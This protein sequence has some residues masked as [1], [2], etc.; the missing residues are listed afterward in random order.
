[1]YSLAIFVSVTLFYLF[2]RLYQE[3]QKLEIFDP[4]LTLRRLSF[5][6]FEGNWQTILLFTIVFIIGLKTHLNIALLIP[7][8]LLFSALFLKNSHAKIAAGALLFASI[9]IL[10]SAYLGHGPISSGYFSQSLTPNWSYVAKLFE[11]YKSTAITLI[12][13]LLP[14]PLFRYLPLTIKF[15]YI[16]F[17]T[18]FAFFFFAVNGVQFHDPRYFIFLFPL[19]NIGVIFGI[20]VLSLAFLSRTKRDFISP[21]VFLI[22]V[23]FVFYLQI[24]NACVENKLFTCPI[25]DKNKVFNLDRWNYRYDE[26]YE[27]TKSQITPNTVVASRTLHNYYSDKYQI[28]HEQQCKLLTNF[29]K[30]DECTWGKIQNK[31]V[32]L[33]VYPDLVYTANERSGHDDLYNFLYAS[34]YRLPLYESPDSRIFIYQIKNQSEL[35]Y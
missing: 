15:S 12:F 11:Y 6:F 26:G 4:K 25:S 17:G 8:M 20:F 33:V 13:F 32:I 22:S 3:A 31:D 35:N 10:L 14:L 9:S 27:A 19:Y 2:I 28:S 23:L 21:A 5:L 30:Q 29:S 16:T 1:M 7:P 24:G 34:P 18:L